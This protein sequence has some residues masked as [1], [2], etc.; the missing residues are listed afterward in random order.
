VRIAEKLILHFYINLIEQLTSLLKLSRL[1]IISN[2][3]PL[4]LS[5]EHGQLRVEHTVGGLATGIGAIYKSQESLWIGWPGYNFPKID[6]EEKKEVLKL[7]G[8]EKCL[9]VFLSSYDIQQ[10][11]AGF[12][13]NTIWPLFHYFSIYTKYD[14]NYWTSYK[15]V[16]EKFCDAVMDVVKPDDTI[17]IHDYQLMLLPAMIR[18][19]IPGAKIGFFLHIP[20]PSYEIFR[21][22]PWRDEVL[23][24]LL[25]ADLVGFHTYDYVRHFLSSVRRILGYEHT[26]S[27]IQTGTRLVKVDLF[28]MGIDYEHFSN[29]ASNINVQKEVTRIKKR[30]GTQK[31]ILS[32]DRLDYTKGIPLRLEAF[33]T[34]LSRKAEYRG[35]ITLVIGHGSLKD[36]RKTIPRIKKTNR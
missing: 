17:W 25:G 16:N 27:E 24:G 2:R 9:P 23:S 10:Y 13:N 1:L 26:L 4:K 28:P 32:F 36:Q 30:S 7:L 20:F 33:D 12:C 22:L 29:S 14:K 31:I 21:L 18:E 34:L 15:K 8:K 11:Y 5:K 19:K 35:K 3:L 6:E